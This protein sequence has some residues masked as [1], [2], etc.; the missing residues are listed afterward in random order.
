MAPKESSRSWSDLP[1]DLLF[2]IFK[3]LKERDA[4]LICLSVY[5]S[6]KLVIENQYPQLKPYFPFISKTGK[7]ILP[8]SI[9][10]SNT[11]T[12]PRQ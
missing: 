4:R 5:E 10:L 1:S 2:T 8:V 11:N 3:K 12:K 9:L 6:W 7:P